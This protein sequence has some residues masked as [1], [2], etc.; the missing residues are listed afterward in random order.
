MEKFEK[1]HKYVHKAHD[2]IK[3]YDMFGFTPSLNINKSGDQYKTV[4]GGYFSMAIRITLMLYIYSVIL[5]VVNNNCDTFNEDFILTLN[6]DPIHF[7][8]KDTNFIFTAQVKK[9]INQ[10]ETFVYDDYA[11]KFIEIR[12]VQKVLDHDAWIKEYEIPFKAKICT[13]E[14]FS[15]SNETIHIF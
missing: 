14:D 3:E 15:Y 2:Y 5:L 4:I 13:E 10:K 9:I 8:Y 6:Y 12:F 11:K 1:A 7:F